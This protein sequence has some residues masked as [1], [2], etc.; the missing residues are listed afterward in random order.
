[1]LNTSM[2]VGNENEDCYTIVRTKYVLIYCAYDG[3]NIVKYFNFLSRICQE[4]A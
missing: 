1:M 2:M 3:I 4:I